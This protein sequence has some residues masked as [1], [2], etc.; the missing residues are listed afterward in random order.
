MPADR[1]NKDTLR[2]LAFRW[3]S[4]RVLT[5]LK[6]AANYQSHR[7]G[8]RRKYPNKKAGQETGFWG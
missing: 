8:T 6:V 5:W 4:I 3:G 2:P 7:S 1:S